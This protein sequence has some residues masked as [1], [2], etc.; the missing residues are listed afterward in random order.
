MTTVSTSSAWS[1][2]C[3]CRREGASVVAGDEAAALEHHHGKADGEQE[4]GHGDPAGQVATRP[5]E[6]TE[7]SFVD[8]GQRVRCGTVAAS[9]HDLVGDR[10]GGGV[11][12]GARD[13]E[14]VA[15]GL[16]REALAVD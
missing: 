11:R 2:A 10:T 13:D 16:R 6:P 7:G 8:A 3:R 15:A 9:D 5:S 1:S 12:T 14:F 4:Q